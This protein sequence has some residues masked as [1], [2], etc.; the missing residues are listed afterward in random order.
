MRE[1]LDGY[2]L[3][4]RAPTDNSPFFFNMLRLRN[5]ARSEFLEFGKLSLNM[6]AVATLA[7]L[8][9]AMFTAQLPNGFIS[10]KLLGVTAAGPQF[11]PPGY[12]I[13]LLYM[14]C[15]AALVLGGPGPLAI[16]HLIRDPT[17]A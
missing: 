12:E 3:N 14:A 9:V 7:V 13:N 8:L 5:A 1:F 6:K 2:P 15:L 11:G 17:K 10:I 4:I 16:D